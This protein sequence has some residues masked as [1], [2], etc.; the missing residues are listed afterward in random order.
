MR[1]EKNQ[2]LI[3]G[4]CGMYNDVSMSACELASGR[5]VLGN[6][7]KAKNV[8]LRIGGGMGHNQVLA[9]EIYK[10]EKLTMQNF[11]YTMR[12][13]TNNTLDEVTDSAA[14]ATAM[15]TGIRTW[16]GYVGKGS[17]VF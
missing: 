2:D 7:T 12:V 13:S 8:I 3:G 10:G 9:G 14:S 15:A 6:V 17:Y 16:N 4:C 1:H 5:I 11:P